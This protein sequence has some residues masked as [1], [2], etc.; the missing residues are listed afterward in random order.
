MNEP[1]TIIAGAY[2]TWTETNSTYPADDGYVLNYIFVNDS[3]KYTA[4]SSASGS[5]HVVILN[6]E[7]T[8]TF[9]PGN[10]KWYCYAEKT[11]EKYIVASGNI[12][13]KPNLFEVS[14]YDMRTHARRTLDAIEATIER[15]ATKEQSSISIA[16]KTLSNMSLEELIKA[17]ALYKEFVKQEEAEEK[18]NEG[19]NGR[20]NILVRF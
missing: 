10:Y 4:T 9:I 7:T 18:I 1:K 12:E 2:Y 15:R 17:R 14:A 19:L 5:D 3:A 8:A 13:I 6:S 11:T 20:K 16:G